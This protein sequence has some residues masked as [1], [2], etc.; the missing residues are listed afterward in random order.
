MAN[1]KIDFHVHPRFRS[2]NAKKVVEAMYAR[3]IDIVGLA[4]YNK[5]IFD[6][7]RKE[8]DKLRKPFKVTNDSLAIK[9]ADE[10]CGDKY[11]L[12]IG[13]YENKGGFH[14]LVFGNQKG[15][16]QNEEL[17]KNIDAALSTDSFAVIDHPFVALN[18][19]DITKEKED[20]LFKLCKDYNNKIAL[21]WNG[22]SIPLLR[23][24]ID[25]LFCSP[26]RLIGKNIKFSDTNK[27]L[28]DFSEILKQ[29][30]INCPIIAD[31]DLHARNR[32]DLYLIGTV[33]IEI[34]V[35]D[36][37]KE[38]GNSLQKSLKEKVFNLEYKIN[39]DYVPCNHFIFSYLIPVGISQV[40]EGLNRKIRP[41]G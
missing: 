11:I 26:L 10:G 39:K 14:L 31:T 19:A 40:S 17:R 36:F 1:E 2:Y 15:I 6:D 3:D 35:K 18:Y 12:R 24:G 27:K 20:F 28:E 29:N 5:D 23:K 21:E 37:E 34:D 38:S 9:I 16:K 25:K 30:K 4:G 13:E 8:F 41:R 22:Y 7:T 33:N 32:E